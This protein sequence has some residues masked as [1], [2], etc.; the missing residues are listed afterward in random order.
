[1]K[2]QIPEDF[3]K[4]REDETERHKTSGIDRKHAI[5]RERYPLPTSLDDVQIKMRNQDDNEQ[6]EQL[7]DADNNHPIQ[8]ISNRSNMQSGKI[9]VKKLCF[10]QK[11]LL[12]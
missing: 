4:E 9:M 1:M 7:M 6:N 10:R 2:D 8:T 3:E 12:L 5:D 11:I